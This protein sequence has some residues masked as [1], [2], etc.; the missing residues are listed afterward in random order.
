[1]FPGR[2]NVLLLAGSQALMLSAI[3]LSMSL[4]AILGALLAPDK[5]LATLPVAAMVVGTAMASLPAAMLMRRWGRRMGFLMGAGLGVVGS[6]L[7]GYALW[8][9]SF[10]L[11]VLGHLLLGSYQGFANYYRF[12]AAEAVDAAHTTRAISWVV[13]GGVVAAFVGPQLGEWGRDWVISGPF[14]GSYLA[15]AALSVAALGLLSQVRL[16]PAASVAAGTARSVWELLSQPLLLT[17]ILGSAVGYSV[18]I[19]VMTATPLAMLGCGLPGPSVTPVI[20]WHVVGMFAP[21]FF[22]GN[23]IKRFGAPRIMQTGF[24]LL[25]G[26]VAIALSGLELLHFAS[27][28]VLLGVGWNFAFVGG[29]ALLTQTYRPAEQLKVQAI[30][31][32][33]VF[34]L[35]AVST[36]SAGWLYDRYGWAT[37]NLAVV[38]FLVLALLASVRTELKTIRLREVL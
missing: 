16:K 24:V 29:T 13:A 11:F 3:V 27:A 20:Q 35:V 26:H 36:L 15:Q 34:G 22:T 31:E 6:V 1:M 33:L 7:A 25:L 5:S 37:L 10:E 12:A 2:R 18:M 19:M 23:L 30:N 21:S 17:S 4:A 38:P 9:Q 14:V 8:Q 28:L 32:F